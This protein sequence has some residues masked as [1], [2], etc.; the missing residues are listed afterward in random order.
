VSENSRKKTLP[1]AVLAAPALAFGSLTFAA[2]PAMAVPA[3]EVEQILAEDGIDTILVYA[4]EDT[5]VYRDG[6]E[7]GT[8]LEGS[9]LRVADYDAETGQFIGYSDERYDMEAFDHATAD[10]YEAEGLPVPSFIAQ[11]DDSD[12]DASEDITVELSAN[13]TEAQVGDTVIL[14]IDNFDDVL[15]AYDTEDYQVAV[16]GDVAGEDEFHGV[17]GETGIE[18]TDSEDTF[19]FTI[20]PTIDTES[21]EHT[22]GADSSF[23][24]TATF[25]FNPDDE[26]ERVQTYSA[27]VEVNIAADG[28]LDEDVVQNLE[29]QSELDEI[30]PG[31]AVTVVG[32]GFTADTEVTLTLDDEQATTT[33]TTSN[34]DG[35]IETTLELPEDIAPGVYTVTATGSVE[36]E[37]ATSSLEVDEWP[38]YVAADISQSDSQAR[39]GDTV[40]FTI[41]NVDELVEEYVT[42]DADYEIG[43]QGDFLAADD[44][45]IDFA[46]NGIE[47]VQD[48]DNEY[49]FDFT[50]PASVETDSET[51]SVEP[52]TDFAFYAAI[53][54]GP[55]SDQ[56][57]VD[58]IASDAFVEV[59]AA[60]PE[61]TVEPNEILLEDFVGDSEEGTGVLHQVRGAAPNSDVEYTV[62]T[63][64]AISPFSDTDEAD[65]N[66]DLSFWIHGYETSDPSVYL[67]DYTTVVTF[68]DAE[69][70]TQE[71]TAEFSVVEDDNT[72]APVVDT[73]EPVS[74]DED[75][76]PAVGSTT[77]LAD[78]GASGAPLAWIAGGLL[79]VGGAFVLYANRARLFGRKN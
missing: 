72:A 20:P 48:A 4:T 75:D 7:S 78:T 29:V 27:G 62:D 51:F 45:I 67:G 44:S 23:V 60:D 57:D 79:A 42:G 33:T 12:E 13:I 19:E 73:D 69:G 47:R 46:S 35:E 18:Q 11:Q 49:T 24:F 6:Q 68:E 10:Q 8:Y 16:R 9:L 30:L 54:F 40:R 31:D 22:V 55:E 65:E 28:D 56:E 37:E 32:S 58:Y 17:F 21:G 76:D 77:Q 64:E 61:L 53:T 34:E 43:L 50:I 63:P 74:N 1:L 14:T 25:I 66:G 59:V 52:G 36:G 38:E 3:D 26:A 15:A 70:E 41:D 39:V 2:A 5:P 71:L